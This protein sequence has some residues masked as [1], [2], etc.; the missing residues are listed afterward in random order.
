MLKT[1][2]LLNIFAETDKFFQDSLINRKIK[3]QHLFGTEIFYNITQ[4]FTV[5]FDQFNAYF[6]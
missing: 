6:L 1:V 4:I 3:K 5:S 2:V